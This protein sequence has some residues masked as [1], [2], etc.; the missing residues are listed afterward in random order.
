MGG[1]EAQR[2]GP[3]RYQRE[4]LSST[5][6][7]TCLSRQGTNHKRYNSRDHALKVERIGRIDPLQNPSRAGTGATARSA[8]IR[9]SGLVIWRWMI[10]PRRPM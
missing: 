3:S 9:S 7:G 2:S 4:G 8:L 6:P 1:L 10:R 5:I